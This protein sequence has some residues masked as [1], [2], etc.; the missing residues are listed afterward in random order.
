MIGYIIYEG[1]S[2]LDGSP[3][4]A[5]VTGIKGSS[6]RKTGDMAQ[7]WIMR[8]D[9][10]PQEAVKAG[11]DAAICGDCPHRGD[12]AGGARSCYVPIW[13]GPSAVWRAYQ[14]GSYARQ[15]ASDVAALLRGRMV[16]LG[17]YGD[18]LAVPQHVWAALVSQAKGWTGYSHAWRDADPSWAALVMASADSPAERFAARRRGFRV[19]RVGQEREAGEVRCP[20]SEEAGRKTVCELCRACMGTAGKARADIVIAPHGSGARYVREREMA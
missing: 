14:R 4:V 20:A 6:N 1:P 13:R 9:M 7:T 16:R 2:R 15:V 5:I 3:I 12:G 18:P 11:A 8:A 17:A 10:H 19:F